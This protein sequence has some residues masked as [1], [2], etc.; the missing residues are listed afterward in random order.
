MLVI[1]SK[2]CL[3]VQIIDQYNS[4]CMIVIKL[5]SIMIKLVITKFNS[6]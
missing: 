6:K 4:I 5:N 2:T 1:G 3:L